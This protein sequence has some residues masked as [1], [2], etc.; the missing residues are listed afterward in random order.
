MSMFVAALCSIFLAVKLH[1][2]RYVRPAPTIINITELKFC[3]LKFPPQYHIINFKSAPCVPH[4][5]PSLSNLISLQEC[6]LFIIIKFSNITYQQSPHS[7]ISS[8]C[9]MNLPRR[10]IQ[11]GCWNIN[12]RECNCYKYLMRR[13]RVHA[14]LHQTVQYNVLLYLQNKCKHLRVHTKQMSS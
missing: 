4:E 13:R 9:N 8:N 5:L 14:I 11:R 7:A 12:I 1:I 6:I 2:L 3:S 10:S